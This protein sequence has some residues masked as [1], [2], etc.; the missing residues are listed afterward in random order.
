MPALYGT[1]K[2][3]A[4]RPLHLSW[5]GVI[6]STFSHPNSLRS[7]L[8]LS[9]YYAWVCQ[10]V[11]FFQV[12]HQNSLCICVMLFEPAKSTDLNGPN[13]EW[14]WQWHPLRPRWY[15]HVCSV[16]APLTLRLLTVQNVP[17][18]GIFLE[19]SRWY[20]VNILPIFLFV[21]WSPTDTK[22]G[23]F[24]FSNP[25][26]PFCTHVTTKCLKYVF[27]QNLLHKSSNT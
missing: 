18:R 22:Y 13:P 21:H 27:C 3:T 10:V 7:I 9:S 12:S 8:I 2:F 23:I 5:V 11:A 20:R 4:V 16:P 14:R 26:G 17:R 1:R 25:T 19:N 24:F 6:Q 15:R